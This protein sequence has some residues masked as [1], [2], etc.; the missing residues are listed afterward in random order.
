MLADMNNEPKLSIGELVR[1]TTVPASTLRYWINKGW[2]QATRIKAHNGRGFLWLSTV[3]AV[4]VA[5]RQAQV[6]R[7]LRA[8]KVTDLHKKEVDK[9]ESPADNP[10]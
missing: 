8:K 7:S 5:N 1:E 2:L 3:E 6:A 9:P 4:E 10:G